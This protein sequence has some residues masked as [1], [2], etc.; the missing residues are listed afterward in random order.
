MGRALV[1]RAGLQQS[2]LC[3]EL[4]FGLLSGVPSIVELAWEEGG[5]WKILHP[6]RSP[7]PCKRRCLLN[8]PVPESL[9]FQIN[10]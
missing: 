10:K 6:R 1:F 8:E 4:E 7:S 2:T 3:A 5:I 9:A